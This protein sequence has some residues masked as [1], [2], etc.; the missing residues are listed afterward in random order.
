MKSQTEEIRIE[1]DRVT[2]KAAQAAESYMTAMQREKDLEAKLQLDAVE[3]KKQLAVATEEIKHVAEVIQVAEAQH[4]KDEDEIK[5]LQEKLKHFGVLGL[6]QS[7]S[8]SEIHKAHR[9]LSKKY[10]PD[11]NGSPDAPEKLQELNLA[12]EALTNAD[13]RSEFESS[14]ADGAE[15]VL[16]LD[17][18]IGMQVSIGSEAEASIGSGVIITPEDSQARGDQSKVPYVEVEVEVEV[19]TADKP[20]VM[21]MRETRNELVTCADKQVQTDE[22]GLQVVTKEVVVKELPP[23][24]SQTR[25]GGMLSKNKRASTIG[26]PEVAPE[27]GTATDP[28]SLLDQ[29]VTKPKKP[30]V[31]PS[32]TGMVQPFLGFIRVHE[33]QYARELSGIKIQVIPNPSPNPNHKSQC[34]ARYVRTVRISTT[35]TPYQIIESICKC[36]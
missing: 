17:A 18:D 30:R 21:D 2:A 1:A 8:V 28:L 20:V 16:V 4:H 34:Y 32:P 11:K 22:D 24:S 33:K 14:S 6:D 23:I 25:S 19:V 7:A 15:V 12:L 35:L 36:Y 3:A 5:E 13:Q 29:P 26:V 9:G 31:R 27:S 10:H